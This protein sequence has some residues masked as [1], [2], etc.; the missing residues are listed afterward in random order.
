[1]ARVE[2]IGNAIAVTGC[3]GGGKSR[4]CQWLGAELGLAVISADAVVH[5]LLRPG[6]AG[7]A[8][9]KEVV[10]PCFFTSAGEIDKP[11]L[12]EA[13]FTDPALKGRVESILHPLVYEHIGREAGQ[14]AR[15]GEWCIVEVPLLFECGW[16]NRFAQVVVVFCR[17]DVCVDRIM[18]RD[19]VGRRQA[20]A[21][22]AVQMPVQEKISLPTTG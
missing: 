9:L 4:V 20:M 3:M 18:A 10:A 17:Q 15:A 22:L 13:I 7:W 11:A 6:R 12:R 8:G 16:R 2:S 5:F 1:M 19:K 21:A 14:L